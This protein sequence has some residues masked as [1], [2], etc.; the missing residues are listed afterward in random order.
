MITTASDDD[1]APPAVTHPET[2]VDALD[3]ALPDGEAVVGDEGRLTYGELQD[4]STRLAADL[5]GRGLR[6]GDRVAILLPN[7]V[8]WVVAALAAHRAG[9]TV[10]PL[11]TWYRASEL[12]HVLHEADVRLVVTDRA[13]FGRD[14]VAELEA[15]GFPRRPSEGVLVWAGDE[16]LP[17]GGMAGDTSTVAKLPRPE[18]T[19]VALILF[20]SGSTA[21]PKPVPLE[22]GKLMA[23]TREIGRRQHVR[24]DDR[25]WL[26]A[27]MFFG[28]GCSNA[29]PVALGVGATL[30]LESRIDGDRSLAFIARERCTVYYGFGATTRLLLTAPSFGTHDLSSLR[31]GTT[32]FSTEEKRLVIDDLGVDGVCSVY[33]LSEAYGHSAMTDAHDDRDVCLHTSGTVLPTQEIRV[34]DEEGAALPPGERGEIELRGCVIDSY[35]GR[36]DLDE[37][38]FRPGGW[39]RTGDLGVLD[40]RGRLRVVGRRKEMLKVKGINIAPA[41]VEDLLHAHPDVAQ[42]YVVGLPGEAGDETMV[43]AVVASRPGHDL[44]A[45]L[46][47]WIRERAASYKVPA[48]IELLAAEEIP[49]T[50]TG[51]VS[52]QLLRDDLVRR[53]R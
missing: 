20:T 45:A 16:E 28:Y 44:P 17:A 39:M 32:G 49:L 33:G 15:A 31:T 30:C 23:N 9:L 35:L 24:S 43:A 47:A 2:L 36:A 25:L 41:E 51:K 42:A 48:R 50:G 7:G 14:T 11:N 37:G 21:R 13:V 52:K 46:V 10:V 19:D 12:E 29:L 40:E 27:P 34:S 1:G 22:H 53:T 5:V 8:R 4:R 18:P 26:G 6:H 3:L 38:V